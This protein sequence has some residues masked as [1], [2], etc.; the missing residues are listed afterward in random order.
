MLGY[1]FISAFAFPYTTRQRVVS[2]QFLNRE[3][4]SALLWLPFLNTLSATVSDAHMVG[5]YDLKAQFAP[6]SNL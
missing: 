3:M 4:I 6:I 2:L 5:S 1:R